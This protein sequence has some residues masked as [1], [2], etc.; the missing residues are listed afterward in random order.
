MRVLYLRRRRLSPAEERRLG[1]RYA[2]LDELL[3]RSDYL[4]VLVPLSKETEGMIGTRELGLMKPS[5]FQVNMGRDRLVDE[6]AL[7]EALWPRAI[8]GAALDVLHDKPLPAGHPLRTLDN[9]ILTPHFAGGSL[10]M[11]VDE[12]VL[13]FGNVQR[14]LRAQRPRW[15]VNRIPAR[16]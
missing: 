11:L 14:V 7:L 6:A 1:V 13:V 12:V 10:S 3:R 15:V 2:P 9:V 16:H 4:T 5:A 8:A